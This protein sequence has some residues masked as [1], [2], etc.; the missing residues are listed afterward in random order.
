MLR[1]MPR[2]ETIEDLDSEKELYWLQT[3]LKEAIFDFYQAKEEMCMRTTAS[4]ENTKHSGNRDI[5][6]SEFI[7]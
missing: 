6:T 3:K 4:R 1:L 2:E 5:N 7:L